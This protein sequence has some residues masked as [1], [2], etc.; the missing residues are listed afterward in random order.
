MG[1]RTVCKYVEDIDFIYN[2]QLQNLQDIADH[3]Y[4]KIKDQCE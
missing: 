4:S 3:I 2:S 1:S